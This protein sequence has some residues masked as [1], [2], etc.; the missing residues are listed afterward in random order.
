MVAEIR[1]LIEESIILP[2]DDSK[3]ETFKSVLV[4]N[5]VSVF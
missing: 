4:A 5:V 2:Q 1:N 3:L